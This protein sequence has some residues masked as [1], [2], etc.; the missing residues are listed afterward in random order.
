MA[1]ITY[2]N[3]LSVEVTLRWVGQ[4]LKEMFRVSFFLQRVVG[5]WDARQMVVVETDAIAVFKKPWD[6]H[7]DMQGMKGN[8]SHVGRW[9]YFNLA[10]YFGR[11]F[12]HWRACSCSVLIYVLW[13]VTLHRV[14]YLQWEH[15]SAIKTTLII[16][17]VAD[18]SVLRKDIKPQIILLKCR[19]MT[20]W[21][22]KQP[23]HWYKINMSFTMH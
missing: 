16:Q 14:T 9:D 4:S 1:I 17:T 21:I 22:Y 2:V 19:G 8:G 23:E 11:D 13:Q 10:S 3:I 20:P 6:R 15:S 18:P 7:V 12:V 5:A